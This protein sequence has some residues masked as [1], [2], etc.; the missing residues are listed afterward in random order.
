MNYDF[1]CESCGTETQVDIPM[2]E[3]TEQKDKQVCTCGGKLVRIMGWNGT[4]SLCEGCYGIDSGKGWT[5]R[6]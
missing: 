3:Y 2:S 4:V 1:K 5:G 6:K